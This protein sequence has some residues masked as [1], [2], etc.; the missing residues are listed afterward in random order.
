M[1]YPDIFGS[2]LIVAVPFAVIETVAFYIWHW[3]HRRLFPDRFRT[4]LLAKGV[5]KAL[6]MIGL[7]I[8]LTYIST[9][10]GW[11]YAIGHV[12]VGIV[13]HFYWCRKHG[14][15]PIWVRPREK[16]VMA[17]TEWVERLIEIEEKRKSGSY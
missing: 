14:V 9:Y 17:S 10:L 11:A 2:P 16:Y 12:L 6:V 3:P 1:K 7:T 13:L 8:V 15:D 5:L 4:A